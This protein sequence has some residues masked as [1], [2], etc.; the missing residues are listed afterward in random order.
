MNPLMRDAVVARQRCPIC[1]EDLGIARPGTDGIDGRPGV[2][3]ACDRP[4]HGR[5]D[6]PAADYAI[7][8]KA[9]PARRSSRKPKVSPFAKCARKIDAALDELREAM[10]AIDPSSPLA[11]RYGAGH[12]YAYSLVYPDGE[13]KHTEFFADGP[14]LALIHAEWAAEMFAG[15]TEACR[16]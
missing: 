5:L 7:A 13:R 11:G 15:F 9:K 1:G 16:G 10:R 14:S 6:R 12:W 2:E 4:Y 8:T 3:G